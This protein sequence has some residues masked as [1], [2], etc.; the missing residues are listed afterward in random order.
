MC[1]R[2]ANPPVSLVRSR[3]P[4]AQEQPA[5]LPPGLRNQRPNSRILWFTP[6]SGL[7][8]GLPSEPTGDTNRRRK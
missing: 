4:H 3:E 1:D 7:A 8:P 6:P 2:Q 5:R